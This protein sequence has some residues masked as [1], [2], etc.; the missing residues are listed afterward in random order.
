MYIEI[1]CSK[2]YYK[3]R[4]T[5]LLC[6]GIERVQLVTKYNYRCKKAQYEIQRKY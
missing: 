6:I 3:E 4:K 1:A 5:V 2:R